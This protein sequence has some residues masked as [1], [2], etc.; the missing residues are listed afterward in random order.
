MERKNNR[1][2][3]YEIVHTKFDKNIIIANNKETIYNFYFSIFK[4][5]KMKIINNIGTSMKH[6]TKLFRIYDFD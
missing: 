6:E 1:K 2:S 4:I 3:L 5:K